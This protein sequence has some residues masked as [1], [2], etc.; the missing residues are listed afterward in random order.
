MM[1]LIH[2][3]V[4]W[5]ALWKLVII[6][7]LRAL[8]HLALSRMLHRVAVEGV[9]HLL[10]VLSRHHV[11]TLVVW[12]DVRLCMALSHTSW[13]SNIIWI[14]LWLHY[15]LLLKLLLTAIVLLVT[16]GGCWHIYHNGI[17]ALLRDLSRLNLLLSFWR[18]FELLTFDL[19]LSGELRVAVALVLNRSNGLAGCWLVCYFR[20]LWLSL[21][22]LGLIGKLILTVG[23]RRLFL[24]ALT[25]SFAT[26]VLSIVWIL[27]ICG[28]RHIPLT[29][30]FL[31]F[32][33]LLV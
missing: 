27:H 16:G 17:L 5:R 11:V 25:L 26:F 4:H 31:I 6:H 21:P 32:W 12:V 8:I 1:D 18:W 22:L 28:G 23:R 20:L 15:L 2:L 3:G 9:W 13:G 33:Y 14:I 30:L 24:R 29:R 7:H 10:V 19:R